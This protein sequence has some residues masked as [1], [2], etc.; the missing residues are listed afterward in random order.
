MEDQRLTAILWRGKYLV[1]AAVATG[2]IAAI[3]VTKL[4]SKVYEAAAIIQVNSTSAPG[5]GAA[6]PFTLQQASQAL[7]TTYATLIDDRSFL[8]EIK[9]VVAGGKFGASDLQQRVSASAIKDTALIQLKADGSSPSEARRLAGDISN[10]FVASIQRSAK[11]VT[12]SDRSAIQAQ[13][14]SLSGQI[15]ALTPAD[16]TAKAEQV[17]SLRAARNFLTQELAGLVASGIIRGSSV[18]VSG[19]PTASSSPIRPRPVLNLLAGILLGFL[20]GLGLAWLRTRFDRGLHSADEAESLLKVP[21]L[22]S[23]PIRRQFSHDDAIVGEAFDVL[24]ANLAFVSLEH[25]YRV[26]TFSSFNPREGKSSVVEGL[27]YS[28]V[29]GGMSVLIV[30]GDVRT[31]T[32]S[33]RLGH[34]DAPGLTS[35]LVGL[36]RLDHALIEIEPGLT[37]LAAGPTPPNPPSLLSSIRTR[38]LIAELREQHSLVIIDSPPVANLADA[39]ILAALSDAVVLVARVG[40]TNR[41]D[42]PTAVANLRHSPTPVVGSVVLEPRTFDE[43][44]YPAMGRRSRTPGAAVPS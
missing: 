2:I 15:Q 12:E 42:L 27:A 37:L 3:L 38:D 14:A 19:P 23:I 16:T 25:N 31:R 26:V 11:K 17:V 35:V 33:E 36:A 34:R 8:N 24:R 9:S 30:D 7:A 28:A 44:Y 6:D 21:T 40:L 43:R 4:S 5:T 41:S 22:G 1:L 10:A 20:A 29:R 18:Q 32:L 13:I 39:S